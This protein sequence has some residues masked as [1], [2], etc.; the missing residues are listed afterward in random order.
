MNTKTAIIIAGPTAVGKTALSIEL[1]RYFHTEIISADSRQCYR[2]LN[3]GVAK[4]APE[5][6]SSVKHHFID[7]HSITENIHAAAFE[8]YALQAAESI[9]RGHDQLIVTGGTGLYLKA[10]T[11]GFDAM[12]A[13][14]E[15]IREAVR[16]I[17]EEEGTAGLRQKLEK[18]DPVFA[19]GN[20]MQNPQRMMR[21]LEFVRTTGTS[22]RNYQQKKPAERPFRIITIGLELPREELYARI[23]AR[24]DKMMGDGLLEEVKALLPYKHLNALQTVGYRELFA[25]LAGEMSL[26]KAV[27]K[28]KQNTRHYAKRQLTWFK[29]DPTI[30]WFHPGDWEGILVFLASLRL[31]SEF[32]SNRK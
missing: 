9:F 24:V 1:A 20:E 3:I 27:D 23:N 32:E 29:A 10:F 28:I 6:L 8:E 25:Y 19:A 31:G 30:H 22:I 12:P 4:P 15:A 7:S 26:E 5:E 17:G 21:A 18:E 2:E 14:P 11:S 13:I 16:K